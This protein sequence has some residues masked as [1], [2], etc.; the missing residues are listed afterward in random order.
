MKIVN[1]LNFFLLTTFLVLLKRRTFN[2]TITT[3]NTTVT[4]FRFQHGFAF[5]TFVKILASVHRHCF[6]FCVPTVGAGNG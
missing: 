4:L 6:F 5:F 3:I 2:T 1:V